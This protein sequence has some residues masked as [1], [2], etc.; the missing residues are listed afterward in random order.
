[1][2][3]FLLGVFISAIVGSLLLNLFKEK[4]KNISSGADGNRT[5]VLNIL[6]LPST[7]L[8]KISLPWLEYI[9]DNAHE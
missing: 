5:R 8:S 1:V 6:Q 2:R 4:Y 9:V 7:C 3:K